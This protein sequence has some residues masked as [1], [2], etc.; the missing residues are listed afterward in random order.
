MQV[1]NRRENI[2]INTPP[3]VIPDMTDYVRADDLPVASASALG[4][5]SVGSGLSVDEN[6][7]VSATATGLEIVTLWE[8]ESPANAGSLDT[9]LA[10]SDD[11]TNYN[12]I[13]INLVG[14]DGKNLTSHLVS[15]GDIVVGS[16]DDSQIA[17]LGFQSTG[18]SNVI[19]FKFTDADELSVSA[20]GSG[21]YFKSIKA[22]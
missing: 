17:M 20:T 11:V 1:K 6:G 12:F 13:V 10:L 22:F 8:G 16:G 9:V 14:S 18:T 15:A 7:E 19:A 3:A 4:C 2:M 21:V 5:I